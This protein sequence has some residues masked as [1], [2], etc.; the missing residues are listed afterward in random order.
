MGW[1]RGAVLEG[2]P[3]GEAS[4]AFHTGVLEHRGG[5]SRAQPGVPRGLRPPSACP[6]PRFNGILLLCCLPPLSLSGLLKNNV[7]TAFYLTK[8]ARGQW[9]PSD[10]WCGAS[11]EGLPRRE[12]PDT[13]AGRARLPIY[14]VPGHD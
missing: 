8:E 2:L 1:R 11:V 10:P 3:T 5:R 6:V 4:V 7:C 13:L 14:N 9:L 12:G